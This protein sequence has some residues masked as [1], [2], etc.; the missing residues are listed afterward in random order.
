MLLPRVSAQ[1]PAV[2]AIALAVVLA[3]SGW[4][5]LDAAPDVAQ[6]YREAIGD[7]DWS[8]AIG[9]LQ[10]LAAGGLCLRR[11]RATT[12][13]A[14]AAIVLIGVGNQIVSG[15]VGVATV[16]SALLVAWAV[17]VAWG[18]ARRVPAH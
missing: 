18:E 14:F 9:I 10:L 17:A 12:A 16:T 8:R 13:A 3:H 11:T 6:H 2:A 5:H 7:G 15:R 1:W 4:L